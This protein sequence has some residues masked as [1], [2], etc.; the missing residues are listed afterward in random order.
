M[1]TTESAPLESQCLPANPSHE[2]GYKGGQFRFTP[3]NARELAE[4]SKLSR[5]AKAQRLAQEHAELVKLAEKGKELALAHALQEKPAP[6]IEPEEQYRLARLARTREQIEQ[7]DK[8]LE[9]ETDPKAIKSLADAL[10]RMV[11]VEFALAKRPKPAAYRTAPEKPKRSQ[12]ST[13]P[14]ED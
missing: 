13:G 1:E 6:A 3:A 12:A 9:A 10:A 14:V 11:D 4:K 8:Q 2:Q 5:L 7:L